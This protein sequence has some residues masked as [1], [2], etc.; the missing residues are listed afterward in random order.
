MHDLV[1]GQHISQVF[2]RKVESVP[3]SQQS[4]RLPVSSRHERRRER[5]RETE[6]SLSRTTV[7]GSGHSHKWSVCTAH[8]WRQSPGPRKTRDEDSQCRHEK[9][10]QSSKTILH[11]KFFGQIW[12]SP[13]SCLALAW[14][15]ILTAA[16]CKFL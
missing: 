16:I 14:P 4:V 15:R 10:L 7:P 1:A 6:P 9:T 8:G 11:R 12:P 13:R 5:R 2:K 3:T